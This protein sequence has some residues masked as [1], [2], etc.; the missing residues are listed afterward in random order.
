MK[1]RTSSHGHTVDSGWLR[2]PGPAEHS[3]KHPMI[4]KVLTIQGGAGFLPSTVFS[5]LLTG[6]ASHLK[7][8][9]K[10]TWFHHG[11]MH[12]CIERVQAV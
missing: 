11:A 4:D 10:R 2:N 12:R 1:P 9:H 5:L 3:G 6:S 7:E 8:K